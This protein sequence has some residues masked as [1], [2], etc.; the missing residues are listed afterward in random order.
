MLRWDALAPSMIQSLLESSTFADAED[1]ASV[2][3][4]GLD[5]AWYVPDGMEYIAWKGNRIVY[6]SVHGRQHS[7]R[8]LPML[9]ATAALW[10]ADYS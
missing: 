1:Y 10:S 6:A 5:G 4:E 8:L 2:E 7:E 9:E 3:I